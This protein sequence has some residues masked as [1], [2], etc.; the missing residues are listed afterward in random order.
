MTRFHSGEPSSLP[1]CCWIH[2][3]LRVAPDVS[4]HGTVERMYVSNSV[5]SSVTIARDPPLLGWA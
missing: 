3:I 5:A 2:S 1:K 4:P